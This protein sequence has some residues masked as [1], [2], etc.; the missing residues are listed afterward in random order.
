MYD[1]EES[2]QCQ[3]KLLE[4]KKFPATPNSFAQYIQF[5]GYM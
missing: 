4:L 3:Q 2:R 1:V 5:L